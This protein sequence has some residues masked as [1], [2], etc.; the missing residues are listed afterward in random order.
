M[1]RYVMR[2][3]ALGIGIALAR[4]ILKWF[5]RLAVALASIYWLVH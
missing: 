5:G 2:G 4:W 1:I 3:I